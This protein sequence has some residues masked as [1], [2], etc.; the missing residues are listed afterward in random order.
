MVADEKVHCNVLTVHVLIHPLPDLAR[1]HISEQEM[2]VL[3][4][5][6]GRRRVNVHVTMLKIL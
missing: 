1:H 6:G 2:I 5:G 4:G 3:G